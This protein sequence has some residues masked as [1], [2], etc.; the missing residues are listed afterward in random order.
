MQKDNSREAGG[1]NAGIDEVGMGPLA[2]PVTAA[3]VVVRAPHPE[4]EGVGDSKKIPKK[5]IYELAPIIIQ[6][7]LFVG[8]GWAHPRVIDA[9][10]KQEAWR[11]ACLDALEHMPPVQR[12]IVDGVISIEGYEGEQECRVKAD[13][14]VWCV[15]A[16]SIVAKAARDRDMKDM[17]AIYTGYGWESNSGYGTARHI[18]AIRE[19]GVTPY[20]RK[21]FLKKIL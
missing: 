11:R 14:D 8:I 21:S 16:A 2:G 3:V 6:K 5:K 20:H 13:R 12:L 9:L 4:I 15:G 7:A 17:A 10:G 1:L 19:F 18:E